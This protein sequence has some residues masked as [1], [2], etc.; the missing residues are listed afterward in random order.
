MQL[1][2]TYTKRI[3][4]LI[5]LHGKIHLKPPFWLFE[6]FSKISFWFGASSYWFAEL[7]HVKCKWVVPNQRW[8]KCNTVNTVKLIAHFE[9]VGWF[10]FW[11]MTISAMMCICISNE[12]VQPKNQ[13]CAWIVNS[14]FLLFSH[15]WN[16]W[17]S[18]DFHWNIHPK[19]VNS[20]RHSSY[21]MIIRR[22]NS[23]NNA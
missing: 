19:A 12:C 11:K 6:H 18:S 7:I 2:P 5:S 22:A 9:R 3:L 10:L 8:V 17:C 14:S 1:N 15:Q 21:S 23:C 16:I 4:H 13:W 20:Q